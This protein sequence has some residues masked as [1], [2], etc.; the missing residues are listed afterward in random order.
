[1]AV[2]T[3]GLEPL[4]FAFAVA[5]TLFSAFV[6]GTV[7]FAMPMIMLGAFAA[8]LPLD[9]A[10]ASLILPMLATNISQGLRDGPAA[11][12]RTARRY[13][14]LIAV[15][16]ATLV[17]S[18][19]LV[20]ILPQDLLFA[21][22]GLP[23]AAYAIAGLAGLPLR[24][25]VGRRRLWETGVGA[26][27]GFFGGFFGVWGPPIVI[28]LASSGASK[29]DSMRAQGVIFLIGAA[30]LT[31]AHVLTGV[32]NKT[33]LPLSAAM[34]VPAMAGLWLGYRAHDR[35]D[36]AGFRRWTLVLLLLTGLNL[37]RRALTG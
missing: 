30:M 12:L 24:F 16:M 32:V 8:V 28:Y 5:V 13:R 17:L 27:A 11:A 33:T 20:R 3:G 1:M 36:Q 18:A 31:F 15:A 29:G 19:Q 7:G 23:V 37:L 21:I 34:V 14:L 6:K 9:A 4:T 22:L 26:V 25:D 35:I 10:L 2:L